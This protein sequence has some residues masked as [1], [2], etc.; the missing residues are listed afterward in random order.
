[1]LPFTGTFAIAV[2]QQCDRQPDRQRHCVLAV[3]CRAELELIQYNV[4]LRVEFAILDLV[5]ELGG[6]LSLGDV[7]AGIFSRVEVVSS[8]LWKFSAISV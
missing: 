4:M 6:Q 3:C 1:M 2:L 7:V 5:F 8:I